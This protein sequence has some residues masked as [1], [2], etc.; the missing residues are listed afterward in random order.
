VGIED[1]EWVSVASVAELRSWLEDHHTQPESAWLVTWKKSAAQEK[2]V[3]YEDLVRELLCF[4]WIDS[5]AMTVD[6]ERSRILIAPRRAK[7][8]WSRPNKIR[9][10]ELIESGR[11]QPAGLAVI[12]AAQASGSWTALDDVENL[13]EPPDLQAALD[14]TPAARQYWD[15][16]SRS[17][18]RG[19]LEW[20]STAKRD[21]T[22]RK[23][24]QETV[25][26]AAE[27]RRAHSA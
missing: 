23:R 20:I 4:G 24:V 10:A 5:K 7:S 11:M 9:V 2:H 26:L 21:E 6:D 27:N 16:F 14:A 22:R 1:N 18:K 3:S 8:G 13:V 19:I 12:E 15:A 17:A 25:E